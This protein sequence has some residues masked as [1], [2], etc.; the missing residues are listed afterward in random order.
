MWPGSG[1]S[2]I[3]ILVHAESYAH[4]HACSAGLGSAVLLAIVARHGAVRSNPFVV[5][6]HDHRHDNVL[7][8]KRLLAVLVHNHHVVIMTY[9]TVTSNCGQPGTGMPAVTIIHCYLIMIRDM[10]L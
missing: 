7:S 3:V 2:S 1:T 5:Q 8:S 10:R 6:C 4:M 9:I